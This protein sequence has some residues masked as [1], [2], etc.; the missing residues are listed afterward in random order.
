MQQH[1]SEPKG[2]KLKRLFF[3][4]ALAAII[5]LTFALPS[6]AEV[7]CTESPDVLE[8]AGGG[9]NSD[10]ASPGGFGAHFA[11][12]PTTGDMDIS[13][14]GGGLHGGADGGPGGG[15]GNCSITVDGTVC[16]GDQGQD[17]ANAAQ[18][19]RS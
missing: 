11:L 5:A 18:S 1:D 4:A 7:N 2:K 10:G 14:G 6:A 17:R 16:A 19:A 9:G 12:D 3:V 15:G 13:G 8:C